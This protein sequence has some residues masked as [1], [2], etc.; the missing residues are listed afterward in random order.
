MWKICPY[1]NNALDI[2]C[3]PSLKEGF[4]LTLLE[5]QACNVPVVTTRIGSCIEATC[6]KPGILVSPNNPSELAK[7]IAKQSR[8]ANGKNPRNFVM[9]NC[10]IELM[11][12][13]Y[14]KLYNQY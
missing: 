3:L 10:S 5:A 6:P 8:G 4:P 7:A 1:S 11:M 9:K 13:Q 2:F 12:Y 14:E